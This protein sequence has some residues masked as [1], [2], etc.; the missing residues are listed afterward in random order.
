M[1][2]LKRSNAILESTRKKIFQYVDVSGVSN[3]SFRITGATSILPVMGIMGVLNHAH[4]GWEDIV[5]GPQSAHDA[6]VF[7][8]LLH[9]FGRGDILCGDRAFCTYE[10]KATLRQKGVHT[11]MRLHQARHA[12]L[13]WRKGRKIGKNQRLV[14]WKKPSRQPVGSTMEAEEWA[15]LAEEI[16]VRLIRFHY[17]DREG[18]KR[19]MVLATT[20]TDAHKYPW[21]DLAAI[22]AQRW[23]IELRLRDVKTTLDLD[24]L[25]VRTPETARK[26]LRMALIAYNLIRSSCQ[27]AGHGAGK[28]LRL[29]SFKGALDT[30]VANTARY[31]RRQKHSRVI[32]EI[33]DSTI[34]MIAEKAIDLR[35]GRWEPRV[36][37]KRPKSF[38][39]LTKPRAEYKECRHHG[40]P[41]ATA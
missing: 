18:K 39:Y 28:D 40:E 33:W 20:L 21:A 24:H 29:M 9:C 16:E 13:D 34:A 19:R 3:E 30:I 10:I 38:S 22:Y 2:L 23:D 35:V 31:L 14:I 7:R 15:A 1:L 5:E 37:K 6:P 8:K 25:R 11:L 4:G 26:A 12:K 36:Q 32:R 17:E 41:R 27:E